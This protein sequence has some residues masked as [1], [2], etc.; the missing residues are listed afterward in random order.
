MSHKPRPLSLR[1][2]LHLQEVN[3]I[4]I[5]TFQSIENIDC[6]KKLDNQL[7]KNHGFYFL[8][9]TKHRNKF[10]EFVTVAMQKSK[11]LLY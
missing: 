10:K 9:F 11:N 8:I 2:Y 5:I 4:S 7:S 1:K 3:L 6:Q